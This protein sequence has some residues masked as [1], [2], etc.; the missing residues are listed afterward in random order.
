MT[1]AMI[2]VPFRSWNIAYTLGLQAATPAR[3]KTKTYSIKVLGKPL[4]VP[5][6]CWLLYFYFWLTVPVS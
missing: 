2:E 5:T 6:L 3:I 4:N 1:D